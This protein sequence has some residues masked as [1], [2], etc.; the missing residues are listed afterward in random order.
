MLQEIKFSFKEFFSKCDQ[1]RK[2]A[3]D[4][5]TFTEKILKGKFYLLCSV[6]TYLGIVIS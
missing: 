3:A 1:I 4:L 5:I 2:I 6:P